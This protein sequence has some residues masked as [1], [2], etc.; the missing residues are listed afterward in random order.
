MG[1]R[2]T[3]AVIY[4]GRV[5]VPGDETRLPEAAWPRLI[6]TG[7]LV[8]DPS[9]PSAPYEG[10]PTGNPL[11]RPDTADDELDEL[12]A[13]AIAS[14]TGITI[15]AARG[16][17]STGIRTTEDLRAVPTTELTNIP[18]I[19]QNTADH[20]AAWFLETSDAEV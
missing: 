8:E 4:R 9:E 3:R 10:N 1:T 2:L 12:A 13:R 18:G 20:L 11:K 19:G 14:E 5:Y 17:V 16:V 6:T 15:T 7:A